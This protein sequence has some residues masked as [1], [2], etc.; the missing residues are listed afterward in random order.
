MYPLILDQLSVNLQ[1]YDELLLRV[2][3]TMFYCSYPSIEPATVSI[4]TSRPALHDNENTI[5][6]C[7]AD[8]GYPPTSSISW[9]KNGRVI[10]TIN[11]DQLMITVAATDTH[12]FGQYIHVSG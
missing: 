10:S 7:T 4:Q 6:N 2:G 12:A 11:K 3:Y 9:V 5:L 8:G 1:Y